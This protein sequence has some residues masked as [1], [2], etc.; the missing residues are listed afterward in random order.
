MHVDPS[1]V[2]REEQRFSA[3]WFIFS[4]VLLVAVLL[5]IGFSIFGGD[6]GDKRFSW[7][8]AAIVAIELVIVAVLLSI[9]MVTEVR[10]DN[11]EVRA[12]PFG[13][14][15][16]IIPIDQVAKSEART[17]RPIIEYGGYGIRYG[18]HGKAY[19]MSGNRGAQLELKSGEKVLIGS[20]KADE[21]TA[22]IQARIH[23]PK[24]SRSF[25]SQLSGHPE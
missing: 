21:L 11:I 14:L 22:A 17:Y 12:H 19:N 15:R 2:F 18:S 25:S 8:A 5:G 9:K 1:I 20:Q 7:P 6:F 24:D 4:I 13:K 10:E 3:V 16:R 23:T